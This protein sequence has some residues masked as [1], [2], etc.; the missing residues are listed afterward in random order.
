MPTTLV[1]RSISLLT[2]SSGFVL[3]TF[4]QI[5]ADKPGPSLF[6]RAPCCRQSQE[7]FQSPAVAISVLV[8]S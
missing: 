2:R 3:H 8:T 5:A 7:V 4:F 6:S 1:R